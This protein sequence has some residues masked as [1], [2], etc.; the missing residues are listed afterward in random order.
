MFPISLFLLERVIFAK[1]LP[2]RLGWDYS[3]DILGQDQWK[4]LE[5]EL[6][7]AKREAQ[8]TVIVSSIQVRFS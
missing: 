4:W 6:E 1:S 3:G 2:F 5:Q 7:L 8:A